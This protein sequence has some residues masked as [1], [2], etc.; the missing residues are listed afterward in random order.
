MIIFRNTR[1]K[2]HVIP[3]IGTRHGY[4]NFGYLVLGHVIEKIT[5]IPFPHYIY[6]FIDQAG[7]FLVYE[8]DELHREHACEVRPCRILHVSRPL[9][10]WYY[11]NNKKSNLK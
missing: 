6:D 4:S 11:N 3:F 5:G 8:G 1:K 9:S 2:K 10:L 7:D